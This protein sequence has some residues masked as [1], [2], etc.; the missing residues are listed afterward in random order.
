M[1]L[2]DGENVYDAQILK[3]LYS[4]AIYEQLKCPVLYRF[5]RL[6]KIFTLI[7]QPLIIL[8]SSFMR[9]LRTPDKVEA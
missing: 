1:R 4:G 8:L 3:K 6:V 9:Y 5:M 7:A 2:L